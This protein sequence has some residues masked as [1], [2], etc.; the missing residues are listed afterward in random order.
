[1]PPRIPNG[2]YRGASRYS[3]QRH[4]EEYASQFA[5]QC[6]LTIGILHSTVSDV[7]RCPLLTCRSG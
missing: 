2:R 6:V 1:M 3:A 4:M 5:K 7:V